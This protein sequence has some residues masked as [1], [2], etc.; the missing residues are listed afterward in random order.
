MAGK[1]LMVKFRL[2]RNYK[3]CTFC[4]M[5][6]DR[7]YPLTMELAS[8]FSLSVTFKNLT[9]ETILFLTPAFGILFSLLLAPKLPNYLFYLNNFINAICSLRCTLLASSKV[10]LNMLS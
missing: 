9:T 7:P 6:L 10:H 2:G 8:P 3:K 5:I 1:K 4:M